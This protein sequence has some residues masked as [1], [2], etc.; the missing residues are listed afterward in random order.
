MQVTVLFSTK[1]MHLLQLSFKQLT[2]WNQHALYV[3]TKKV[4]NRF[5]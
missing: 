2:G 3:E 4:E 1:K 5:H